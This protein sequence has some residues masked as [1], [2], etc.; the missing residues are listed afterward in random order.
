MDDYKPKEIEQKWQNYWEEKRVFKSKEDPSLLKYYCLEMFPYPS[1]KIHMGHVRNYTIGDVIARYKTLRGFNVLHPIGWD[2][3]GLP[4]ENAAIEHKTHPAKWTY[5]NIEYMKSQ[6]KKMGFSYD[7]SREITT[8]DPAYYRWEQWVF[9]KMLEKGLVYRKKSYVN[10]CSKCNTVLANEQVEEGACWRCDTPVVFKELPQ[11]F[12]RITNYASELLKWCD[13]LKG[14]PEKVLSMQ[15]NWIGRS[16]GAEIDFQIYGISEKLTVFTTRPDTLYGATFVCLAP[17]HPFIDNLLKNNPNSKPVR[18]FINEVLVKDTKSRYITQSK[19]GMF[20]G[21]YCIN[22]ANNAHL[23]VYVAEYVLMEYGTGV[24][25]GVPAHDQRD[26]EFAKENNLPVIVVIQPEGKTLLSETMKEAYIESGIMTNSGEFDK[27]PS[28]H[29]K[30]QIVAK[31]AKTGKGRKSVRYRLR[32]WGVSRQRYWGAPIPVIYCDKCGILSVNE[33]ELP[34]VLPEDVE[35]N[36]TGDSPLA[37]HEIFF[38]IKCY[39]CGGKARRETD[40]LDT[41]VESSWY[42]IRYTSPE[43]RRGVADKNKAAYWLPVDQYIG[44]IEHAILHLLYARFFTKVFRDIGVIELDEPFVNLLTQGMVIKDGAK[45]SKSKGNVVNPD[46]LIEKYGADT[47]RL[48]IL[49]ASPPERDLDWSDQGVEGANRFLFRLWRI[50]NGFMPEIN[51]VR[52]YKSNDN[53]SAEVHELRRITNITIK[54][55]TEDIENNFHF[56][57]AISALMEFLNYLSKIDLSTL[58][59]NRLFVSKLRGSVEIFLVLLSP[60]TPHIV[61]ELWAGLGNS[62]SIFKEKWPVWDKSAIKTD[63][64]EMVIQVNGKVRGHLTVTPG[65]N[66]EKLRQMAVLDPRVKEFLGTRTVRRI[67]VVP[68]KLV[69]IVI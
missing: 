20:T 15:K 27:I 51:S 37:R 33:K 3:F 68:D 46:V 40:T 45:M 36:P 18:D 53:H 39:K 4:A 23:P 60:F 58:R 50:I 38:N 61:E 10:W 13:E 22:P 67:V 25:M 29:A 62:K 47:V 59:Q 16:E 14:W 54:K 48:F 43:Y 9:I 28:E 21:V 8:C 55:V 35:F 19:K 66:E 1:G 64:I 32:D 17:E 30:E 26:F 34:V 65:I 2:A 52:N 24:V 57:T 49:F 44:G 56:N 7:W 41:F 12:F 6:L 5:S 63:K 31:L 42:F 69:N 11:W